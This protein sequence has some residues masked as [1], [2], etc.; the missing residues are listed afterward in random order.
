VKIMI[1]YRFSPFTKA[2]ITIVVGWLSTPEVMRWWGEPG[3]QLALLQED[4][5]EPLMRQWLV[6]H[7]GRPFAYLQAYEAHTWPQAHLQHLP[8]GTQVVDAFIGIPEMLGRGHGSRF[9]R[10]FATLLIEE[11]APTVAIDPD[12]ANLRAR[13]AYARAGF[14][15]AAVVDSADGPVAL[16]IFTARSKCVRP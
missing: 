16:M 9:L 1:P 15:E 13:Q 10:S 14:V 6:E 8:Y 3:E 4:L 11:G 2:D 12:V 7:R 5:D